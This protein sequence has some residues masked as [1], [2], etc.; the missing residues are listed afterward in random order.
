MA[1]KPKNQ[2]TEP[3]VVVKTYYKTKD[4]TGWLGFRPPVSDEELAANY[5]PVTEEEWNEHLASMHHEPTAAQLEKRAKKREIAQLK[6]EL[7]ATDYVVI[8]IAEGV[9]TAE[10]Y[11]TVIA[12]RQ[13]CRS[14]IN[15]LEEDL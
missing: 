7:A 2:A 12:R 13:E 10:E 5:V 9:A 14:R 8:K 3:E 11:A 6:G 1:R 4:G 15:E